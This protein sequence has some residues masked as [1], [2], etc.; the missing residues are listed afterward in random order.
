MYVAKHIHEAVILKYTS[1][2]ILE[3]D[4]THVMN[5]AKLFHVVVFLKSTY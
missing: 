1:G 4:L 2:F 5:V 3:N